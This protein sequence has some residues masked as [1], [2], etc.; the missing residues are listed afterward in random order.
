MGRAPHAIY[1]P[2]KID[3]QYQ[4]DDHSTRQYTGFPK[5]GLPHEPRRLSNEQH[6]EPCLRVDFILIE[7]A[8]DRVWHYTR[9]RSV[10][11]CVEKTPAQRSRGAESICAAGVAV[12]LQNQSAW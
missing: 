6:R 2:T 10:D 8:D 4:R 9:S 1:C 12:E 11:G 5:D 3:D 7:L